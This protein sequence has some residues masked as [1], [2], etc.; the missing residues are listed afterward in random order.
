VTIA[1]V[2]ALNFFL[3]SLV[4]RCFPFIGTSLHTIDHLLN[5]VRT[6]GAVPGSGGSSWQCQEFGYFTTRVAPPL[7][8]RS[9]YNLSLPYKCLGFAESIQWVGFSNRTTLRAA[10]SVTVT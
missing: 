9:L 4:S 10:Q 6:A 5:T 8:A 7:S 3:Q 2:Y 1:N